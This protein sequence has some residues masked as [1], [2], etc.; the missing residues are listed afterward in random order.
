LA[1][2]PVSGIIDTT[3]YLA[4]RVGAPSNATN[5]LRDLNVSIPYRINSATFA[6]AKTMYNGKDFNTN[7]KETLRNPSW[8]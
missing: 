6:L 5:Y 7:Y 8:I 4:D 2:N 3:L 1:R